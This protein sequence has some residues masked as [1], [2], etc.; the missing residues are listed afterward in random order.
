[1]GDILAKNTPKPPKFVWPVC[2]IGPKVW[3]IVEKRLHWAFVVHALVFPPVAVSA[4][5]LPSLDSSSLVV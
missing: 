1:M 4:V 5:F 2:P 3:D